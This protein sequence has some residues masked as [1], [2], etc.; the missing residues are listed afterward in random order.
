MLHKT[1]SEKY[2]EHKAIK[3]QLRFNFMITY[4]KTMGWRLTL[5]RKTRPGAASSYKGTTIGASSPQ[6]MAT[7]IEQ[8]GLGSFQDFLLI[9]Y[10]VLGKHDCPSGVMQVEGR[11][12][13]GRLLID[14]RPVMVAEAARHGLVLLT[15]IAQ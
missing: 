14:S 12:R 10:L 8:A 7:P 4:L 1:H 5:E 9:L 13:L 15:R 11:P 3:H 6:M 2:Q